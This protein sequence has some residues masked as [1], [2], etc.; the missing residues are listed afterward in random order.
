LPQARTIRA[1]LLLTLAAFV[2]KAAR[3]VDPSEV[4]LTAQG[5][6]VRA[7]SPDRYLADTRGGALYGQ[8]EKAL[9]S[10]WSLGLALSQV[11]LQS[12]GAGSGHFGSLDLIGR[13]WFRPWG[14]FNPYLQAGVGG[15]L[16][17]AAYKN[18]WGDVLHLQLVLGSSYV[19]DSH[20]AVDYGVGW[21][22]VAP[23]ETPHS[24]LAARLGVNYRYGTQPHV[25]RI[26]P[27]PLSA[28]GVETL[29]DERVR[30]AVGKFEYTVQEGDSLYS[31]AAKEKALKRSVLWPILYDL[32]DQEIK[33]PHRIKPG[34]VILIKRS[35]TPEEA[36]A[37]RAVAAKTLYQ[38]PGRAR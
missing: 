17:R 37:A 2:P 3:A 31:I 11:T 9:N 6:F 33:D 22:A 16:F 10:R 5:A 38:R 24:Y 7:V 35:Y 8:I 29:S 1:A 21:H 23:L 14:S 15:N 20:W 30:Q 25:N 19:L 12:D 4:I 26:A 18:P 13:R 32:N 27:P 36:E 28:N 34:Q